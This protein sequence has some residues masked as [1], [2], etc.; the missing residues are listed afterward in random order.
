MLRTLHIENMAVIRSL[1]LNPCAG[2]TVLTGE[3][4]AGKSVIIDSINFLLGQNI[5]R[6]SIRSGEN[7][8]LVSGVFADIPET[9][10]KKLASL[11]I[12]TADGE[13][14]LER[15][16]NAEGRNVC[17]INGRTVTRQLLR[18]AGACLINVHGQNDTRGL[19]DPQTRLGMIDAVAGNAAVIGEYSA[20]Y[21]AWSQVQ[22][23]LQALRRSE[24]ENLRLRD[25]LEF[26]LKEI[27]AAKLRPGEE[28]ALET[29][30]KKLRSM[31][32]IRRQNDIAMRAIYRNEKGITASFLA[33]RAADSLQKLSDV[34]PEYAQLSERL[35][36]CRYELDDIAASVA[37]VAD[38]IGT[39]S[40]E[41]TDRKLDKI[42]TR[43]E[44][45]A[46]LRKKYGNSVEEIIA[47]GREAKSRLDELECGEETA[48][49]LEK[50]LLALRSAMDAAA[51]KL[52]ESRK[53]AAVRI[54]SVILSTLEYLDMPKVRFSVCIGEASPSPDGYDSVDFLLS[55][56][57]G[58]PML[59]LSKCASG[60]ELSRVMLAVKCAIADADGIPTIIF[61]EIDTGI[62]GRTSRKVGLK[63]LQASL[64]AQIMCVTHS[65]QIA[66]LAHTHLRI[67]KRVSEGRTETAVEELS[68]E[69]RINETA[70]IL[71]GINVTDAQRQAAIDL[72][73][74]QTE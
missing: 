47:F 71:G 8:A 26:Q 68:G 19:E 36:Q 48:A 11:G 33:D 24:S 23:R 28:E 46:R 60:G 37:S 27:S 52:T 55:A 70:R 30:K 63:L 31:E 25:M 18:D 53:N 7:Q 15:V 22:T 65:A 69:G 10:A 58:E 14:M 35:R 13:I 34:I 12:S 54:Q 40:P 67:S 56:N 17:R 20:A 64:S 74:N 38:S 44:I 1:D 72:I 73:S 61:D 66:S 29:E 16:Q 50:E 51:S 57:P 9:A 45:I 5:S 49:A 59:P 3:T 42:E 6:D 39:D 41:E 2:F 21:G 32:K 4:G 62:S 43:L